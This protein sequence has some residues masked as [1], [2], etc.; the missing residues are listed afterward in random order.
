MTIRIFTKMNRSYKISQSC[1]QSHTHLLF[2]EK[3]SS[4]NWMSFSM[5]LPA[6]LEPR[7]Q[8]QCSGNR[9]GKRRERQG[10][11]TCRDSLTSPRRSVP[12]LWSHSCWG[13][14]SAWL[15]HLLWWPIEHLFRGRGGGEG[16]SGVNKCTCE[17]PV[18]LPQ[19]TPSFML[20]LW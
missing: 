20:F 2:G 14:A 8:G 7:R 19:A 4:W 18:G 5:D 11:R 3:L 6:M 10:P 1:K 13:G 12:D 16:R 15:L 17:V 9:R